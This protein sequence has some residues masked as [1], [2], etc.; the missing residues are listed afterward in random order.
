[1]LALSLKYG[2]FMTE[3]KQS[4]G[5]KSRA[6]K[7]SSE[8]RSLIA[9]KAAQSRWNPDQV[10][11]DFPESPFAKYK[12][13]LNLG[14]TEIECYVLDSGQRV[15]SL[16]GAVNLIANSE[17]GSLGNYIGID[18]LKTLI[19]KDLIL[20]E[21][22]E[23]NIPGTQFKAKSINAERFI[24]ICRAYVEAL[25]KG[26]LKTERQKENAIRCA[27]LL[28][29]C[30]KTGLIAL[31]DEATGF[32]Y[33][34]AHDALQVKLMAFISEEL[35][36]WEKTFPDQLWEEFGRLT[37]WQGALH[38]R[39][40]WWGKLIIEL[41]YD[42]LDSDV[43][44]YLKENKPTPGIRWHQQ[45]T[46]NYGVRQLVSRCYEVIGVAK[47]C[48]TINELREKVGIL[49]GKEPVQLTLYLPPHKK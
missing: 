48:F 3:S 4:K 38:H 49:Y 27:M 40:K 37:N 33:E 18:G 43:S 39:P 44:K 2:A 5:G 20:G 36:A 19:D 15:L 12:G 17:G 23:F 31:I 8:E 41:I 6:E 14:G 10:N 21:T 47:T 9:Q 42:T 35:R 45:L 28:I 25:E 24:D 34:R 22:Q 26:L 32:Q 30:A 13:L 29:S 16:R 1:M 46:Q 11:V 7:L